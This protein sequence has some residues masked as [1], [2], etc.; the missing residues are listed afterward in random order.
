MSAD[1][2]GALERRRRFFNIGHRVALSGNLR[3]KAHV[4]ILFP[5]DHR[6]IRPPESDEDRAVLN[7]ERN[8]GKLLFRFV[9]HLID[10]ADQA[11]IRKAHALNQRREQLSVLLVVVSQ[12]HFIPLVAVKQFLRRI[13]KPDAL[14][15]KAAAHDTVIAHIGEIA[16]QQRIHI[17][18]RHLTDRQIAAPENVILN[19]GHM[20][21]PRHPSKE[22]THS[23]FDFG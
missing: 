19:I 6:V 13:G 12:R 17:A 18:K 16:Q 14:S 15:L 2:H 7:E 23:F 20:D 4:E 3:F 5:A 11:H 22:S 10:V 9:V 1:A 21:L 8:A